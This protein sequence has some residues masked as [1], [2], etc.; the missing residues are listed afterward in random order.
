[1]NW[2]IV[3]VA[4]VAAAPGLWALIQNKS[5]T[6]AE[7]RLIEA[8]AKTSEAQRDNLN[9]DTQNKIIVTLQSETSKLQQ[10]LDKL[11]ARLIVAETRAATSEVRAATAEGRSLDYERMFNTA[12]SEIVTVGEK[13]TTERIENQGRINILALLV[14]RLIEQVKRLGGQPEIT[15]DESGLLD[16]MVKIGGTQEIHG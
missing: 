10:K 2:E 9:V 7:T 14:M 8:Q 12:R 5:K 15:D 3:L 6:N 1:M 13:V 11:E 16:K 4:I